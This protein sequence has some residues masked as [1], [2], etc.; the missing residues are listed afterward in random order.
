MGYQNH[1]EL[2]CMLSLTGTPQCAIYSM[3][4]NTLNALNYHDDFDV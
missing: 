4:T 1:I 3:L 2:V